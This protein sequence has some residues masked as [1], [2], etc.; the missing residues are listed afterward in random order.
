[1]LCRG[2]DKYENE[3]LIK[4]GWPEDLW[5]H[6]DK[7][8]SAHV[9][10]RLPSTS[11]G[12]NEIPDNIVLECAALTKANSIEGCKLSSAPVVY[13]MHSNL[14]KDGSMKDGQVRLRGM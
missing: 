14:R 6:V 5:F 11:M 9:Y 7:L 13:T 8:S 3:D 1:M 10:L 12:I 4:Y 2:R